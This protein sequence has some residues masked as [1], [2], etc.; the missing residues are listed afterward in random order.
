MLIVCPNCSESCVVEDDIDT[1]TCPVCGN[2]VVIHPVTAEFHEDDASASEPTRIASPSDTDRTSISLGESCQFPL[3]IGRYS[4]LS[5]LGEGGFCQVYLAEDSKLH[6]KVALKIPKKQ[7]LAGSTLQQFLDEARIAAKLRHPGIVTIFDVG[8]FPGG[9]HYISMEHVSGSTLAK[10]ISQ[11][12]FSHEESV[13]LMIKLAD[14]IHAAIRQDIVHRDL[15]PSNIMLDDTGEPRIVDF[16][17]A[18]TE[19]DLPRLRNEVAGTRPYM[20][21]EQFR[22]EAHRLDAR[23]DIWSLGVIFYELLTGRRPFTGSNAEIPD[24]VLHREPK[25]PRQIDDKIPKELEEICLRCLKKSPA[26]RYST[27]LDLSDVLNSW[28]ALKPVTTT[29]TLPSNTATASQ[30]TTVSQ[31]STDSLPL[32]LVELQPA[33]SRVWWIVGA[34]AAGFVGLVAMVALMM[35]SPDATSGQ[36]RDNAD[37]IEIVQSID[38]KAAPHAW[39]TLLGNPPELLVG[40]GELD[41]TIFN[42]NPHLQDVLVVSKNTLLASFGE[43]SAEKFRLRVDLTKND[44]S[45]GVAG[46]IFGYGTPDR[47]NSDVLGQCQ[48]V[49]YYCDMGSKPPLFEIRRSSIVYR[50]NPDAERPLPEE[51]IFLA[52]TIEPSQIGQVST[53]EIEIHMGMVTSVTWDHVELKSLSDNEKTTQYISVLRPS[54][55]GIIHSFGTSRFSNAQFQ[56]L[57]SNR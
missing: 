16:G 12:R 13:R 51:S 56:M 43:T 9:V 7:I 21:P 52:Q 36:G 44:S 35:I 49:Y 47:T 53:L 23:T 50:K 37:K 46:L 38:S 34:C 20:S 11:G 18:V 41:G 10:R 6:R 26:D 33:K 22:G 54:K 31:A 24:E 2:T 32:A 19:E 30:T 3:Q 42:Y 28:L 55:V 57:Q 1:T 29:T 8:E 40:E 39:C 48:A 15:K 17:L 14:A 45:V 5:K 27:A 25:P 4:I